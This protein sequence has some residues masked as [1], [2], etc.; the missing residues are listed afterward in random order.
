[1]WLLGPFALALVIP[2]FIVNLLINL[3]MC[4]YFAECVRESAAGAVRAPDAFATADLSSM[5]GQCLYLGACYAIFA[6]PAAL[7]SFFT[8]RTDA[9]FWALVAYGV[10]FFPMGLLAAVMFSSSTAFNPVLW[11]GSILS[12]FFQY[13]GLVLLIGGI[14]V[15]VK[16]L[17]T[18]AQ[19]ENI[20]QIEGSTM[21]LE[22]LFS[23]ILLYLAFVVAHLL[24]RFYWRYQE[25]LNWEV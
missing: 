17:T 14:V 16:A 4:W 20:Q 10:F 24:G 11:I 25:K 19:S 15:G 1:M 23:C 7:Y 18:M 21:L 6:L 22:I 9:T 2:S 8:N 3:Y 13:C 5:F 12:T